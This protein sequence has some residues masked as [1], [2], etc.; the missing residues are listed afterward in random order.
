MIMR[1]DSVIVQNVSRFLIPYIQLY[2]W[3][4]LFHGHY[5]PGGGFQ[6][7]VLLGAS[8]ILQ[9]LIGDRKEILSFSLWREFITSCFGLLLFAGIGFGAI[10]AGSLFLD[11]GAFSFLAES[12][13]DRRYLAI[14]GIELGV[15]LTVAMTLVII[16]HALALTDQPQEEST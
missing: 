14:Y 4:V 9:M 13:S 8:F 3:Y 16:F 10:M 5:S 7:G 1:H 6:A 11:Y 12:V 2:A 15:T